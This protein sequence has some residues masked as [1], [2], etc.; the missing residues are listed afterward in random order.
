MFECNMIDMMDQVA[1]LFSLSLLFRALCSIR[2]T[3]YDDVDM[4]LTKI[5]GFGCL[6]RRTFV[7]SSSD[8]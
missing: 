3:D 1:K 4:Q 2:L 8:E 7:F 5:S 6:R